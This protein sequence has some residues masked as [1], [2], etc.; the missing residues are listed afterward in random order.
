MVETSKYLCNIDYNFII[1]SG[2]AFFLSRFSYFLFW[3][4]TSG[5]S[6]LPHTDLQQPH[7]LLTSRGFAPLVGLTATHFPNTS[8][9][10]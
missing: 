8:F 6:F 3:W 5:R 7:P 2:Y 9:S 4:L 10:A 1:S